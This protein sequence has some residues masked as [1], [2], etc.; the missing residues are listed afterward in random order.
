[1]IFKVNQDTCER[2]QEV[3]KKQADKPQEVRI[4]IA[5]MGWG[6]PTFGLGLDQSTEEDLKETIHGITFIIEKYLYESMGEI[7]VSWNGYSYSVYATG[8]GASNC[9]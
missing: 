4:Y 1:M 9:G 7:S 5:G 3:L 2:I 6:G 8:I